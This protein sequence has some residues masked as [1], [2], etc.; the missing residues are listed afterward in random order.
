MEKL[1]DSENIICENITIDNAFFR[2]L[3]IALNDDNQEMKT[4]LVPCT[5]GFRA[6]ML[7]RLA[8]MFKINPNSNH[9]VKNV[10]IVFDS[11]EHAGI[12]MKVH[13]LIVSKRDKKNMNNLVPAV[14]ACPDGKVLIYA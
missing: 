4:F 7:D 5:K 3:A 2:M 14:V 11:S 12:G 1:E 10:H 13:Y 9:I 6:I 8:K